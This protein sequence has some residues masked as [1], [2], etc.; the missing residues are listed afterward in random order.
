VDDAAQLVEVWHPAEER[1][2]IV[3]EV[4]SW[5]LRETEVELRI[6]LA[7]LFAP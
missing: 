7:E 4:L 6:P 5:R 1:P 2:A 3:T